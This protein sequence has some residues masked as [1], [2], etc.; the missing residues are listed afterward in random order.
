MEIFDSLYNSLKTDGSPPPLKPGKPLSPD[1]LITILPSEEP[2]ALTQNQNSLA[3]IK[4]LLAGDSTSPTSLQQTSAANRSSSSRGEFN[5]RSADP[6]KIIV[7]VIPGESSS[8]S[9]F[10]VSEKSG[11]DKP[12]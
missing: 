10:E 12:F 9:L 7:S 5:S 2:V 8:L 11:L 1:D 4:P 6:D 3:A